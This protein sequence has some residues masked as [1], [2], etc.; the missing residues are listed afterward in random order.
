MAVGAQ[1]REARR[2]RKETASEV[3][4]AT[5]MKVQIVEAIER[6]DFSKIAAPIYGKGF[7]RL[8]AE[9]VGLDPGPLIADY[10][11]R[12]VE[13]K[14]PSLIS[15]EVREPVSGLDESAEDT[16]AEGAPDEDETDLFSR[17]DRPAGKNGAQPARLSGVR[18]AARSRPNTRSRS[19]GD[20]VR[21][22]C[23][24]WQ[25]TCDRLS[26]ACEARKHAFSRWWQNKGIRIPKPASHLPIRGLSIALGVIVV[27]VFVAS[28]L[29][30]LLGRP[31]PV[32]EP[33]PRKTGET[34]ELAVPPPAPYFD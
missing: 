2:K 27:L 25:A 4:A 21:D 9:H 34:L 6:E 29:S 18:R 8:F 20:V 19:A 31:R 17:I 30:R 24:W 28:G 23:A 33:Q 16:A 5:R 7:I 22:I 1:L 32:V 10:T 3:A 14:T 11:A 15:E 13:A 26:A 12:F